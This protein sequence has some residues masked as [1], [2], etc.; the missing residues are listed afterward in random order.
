[1]LRVN[2][3]FESWQEGVSEVSPFMYE[4]WLYSEP[5]R[6]MNQ[7]SKLELVIVVIVFYLEGAFVNIV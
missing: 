7:T 3:S 6:V 2:K 1:M 5:M 4:H